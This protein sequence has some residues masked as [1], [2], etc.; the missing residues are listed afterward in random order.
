[1]DSENDIRYELMFNL[2]KEY[3]QCAVHFNDLILRLRTQALAALAT[4]SALLSIFLKESIQ[5]PASYWYVAIGMFVFSLFW[6]A[7]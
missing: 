4:L 2:W 5:P 3:E 7:L 6:V 1:M